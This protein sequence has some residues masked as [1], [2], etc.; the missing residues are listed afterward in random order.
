MTR[1][2]IIKRLREITPKSE[3]Q[4]CFVCGRF[5]CVA[6]QHHLLPVS[7]MADFVMKHSLFDTQL[8]IPTV[9]LCPNHHAIWHIISRQHMDD[10]TLE[11][12]Q[13]LAED[14]IKRYD[15]LDRMV[16]TNKI[17]EML[18]RGRERNH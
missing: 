10:R 9:W 1:K 6:Q 7:E 18:E 17:V 3:R 5:K 15:E 13:S 16:D 11:A 8:Y 4:D 12:F 2:E 14:E